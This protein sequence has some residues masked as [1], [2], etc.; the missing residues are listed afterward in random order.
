MLVQT[1][2]MV[3]AAPGDSME[4]YLGLGKNT[5]NLTGGPAANTTYCAEPTCTAPPITTLGQP[6]EGKGLNLTAGFRFSNHTSVELIGALT[7]HGTGYFPTTGIEQK[8][9]FTSKS[10]LLRMSTATKPLD[11]YIKIGWGSFAFNYA[12]AI[13]DGNATRQTST[14]KGTGP[15]YGGGAE[16]LLGRIGFDF[17]YVVNRIHLKTRDSASVSIPATAKTL[18][19]T[20]MYHFTTAKGASKLF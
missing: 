3:E 8:V 15:I 10:S 9:Y 12:D 2:V 11:L 6:S 5:T 7:E 17:G 14:L 19:I 20:V 4:T 16:L 13:W 1:Q 18:S